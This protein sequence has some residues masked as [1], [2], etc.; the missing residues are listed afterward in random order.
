MMA[1]PKMRTV[2]WQHE[3]LPD[4]LWLQAI[5]EETGGLPPVNDALEILDPFVLNPPSLRSRTAKPRWKKSRYERQQTVRL[6][7]DPRRAGLD[8]KPLDLSQPWRGACPG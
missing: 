4:F 3:R 6:R 1:L 7:R 2:R 8:R 5:R